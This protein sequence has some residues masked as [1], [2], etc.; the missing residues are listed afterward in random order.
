MQGGGPLSPL[1]DLIRPAVLGA[2]VALTA[3]DRTHATAQAVWFHLDEGFVRALRPGDIINLTR[4]PRGGLALSVIRGNALVAAIGAVTVVPLAPDLKATV[5]RDQVVGRSLDGGA[6][7]S[8]LHPVHIT[9]AE[10][11]PRK[12]KG[13][14]IRT[15]YGAWPVPQDADECVSIVRQ[16]SFPELATFASTHLLAT[17][18]ALHVQR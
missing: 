6:E 13:F 2:R 4:S 14:T 10:A 1:C 12:P 15:W 7:T 16:G 3:S 17:S 5:R 9:T 8:W 18:D 11:V